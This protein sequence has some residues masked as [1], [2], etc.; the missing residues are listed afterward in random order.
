MENNIIEILNNKNLINNITSSCLGNVLNGKSIS[1]YCGFDPTADSLH[2]GSLLPLRVLSLFKNAGYKTIALIGGATASIG[3]PSGKNKERTLLNKDE[4]NHNSKMISNLIKKIVN[5]DF[6]LNNIDWFSQIYFLDFIRDVGKNFNINNMLD[7]ESVKKRLETTGLS[8]TEFSY[9]LLQAFDFYILM[10]KYNC[11]LQIGGSDQWGNITSGIDYI[12]KTM[13]DKAYGLT[14]DLLTDSNGKKFGKSEGN[15]IWLDSKKTD[16]YDFYQFF[17]RLNDKNALL[18][19]KKFVD[20]SEYEYNQIMDDYTKYP[21]NRLLQKKLSFELTKWIHGESVAN[22]MKNASRSIRNINNINNTVSLKDIKHK[23]ILK[24]RILEQY[25]IVDL[26]YDN[27]IVNSKSEI[28]RLIKGG[29]IYLNNKRIETDT[30]ILQINDAIDIDGEK[31][32]NIRKGKKD[33]YTFL[34]C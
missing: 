16:P 25:N 9:Q 18:L 4:I 26:L 32:L 14:F 15:N 5:P 3:D 2:I 20:V 10:N 23:K 11:R 13:N 17:I 31:I 6:I 1:V 7:K 12:N 34:I 27:Q 28:R 29:G 33:L 24:S 22:E 8:F 30:Y 19:F 21:E